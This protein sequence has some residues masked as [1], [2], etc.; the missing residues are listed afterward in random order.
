MS[1]IQK[2]SGHESRLKRQSVE[3]ILIALVSQ[4]QNYKGES[5]GS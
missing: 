3:E 4:A 2:K 1:A 5:E